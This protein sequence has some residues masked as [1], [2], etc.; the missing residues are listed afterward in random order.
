MTLYYSIVFL[1]LL[2]EVCLRIHRVIH[3]CFFNKPVAQILLFLLLMV[4]I[5]CIYEKWYLSLAITRAGAFSEQM[6]HFSF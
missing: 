2:I 5:S 4:R 3:H 6:A 1:I